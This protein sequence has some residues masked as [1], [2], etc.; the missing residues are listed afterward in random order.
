MLRPSK[1]QPVALK[2]AMVLLL[3]L[4]L[5][6]SARSTARAPLACGSPGASYGCRAP[7]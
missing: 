7:E 5:L 3:L 1:L 2:W 4:L 6:L